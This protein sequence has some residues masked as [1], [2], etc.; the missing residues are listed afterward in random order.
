[1]SNF[2]QPLCERCWIAEHGTFDHDRET[3]ELLLVAVRQPVRALDCGIE[4]CCQCGHPTISGIYV[5]RDPATVPHP[6]LDY[7]LS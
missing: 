3:G 5:R 2:T 7:A 1:M 4:E 6:T